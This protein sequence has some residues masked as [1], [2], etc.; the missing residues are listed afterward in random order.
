MA[1]AH[2]EDPQEY[3]KAHRSVA[4]GFRTSAAAW[5]LASQRGVDMPITEQVHQV[6]HRGRPLLDA[7]KALVT[8]AHKEELL[9][10][11]R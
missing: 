7:M 9:G 5:A 6:L 1:I 11:Q 10:L 2:G 3:V 4:E 8:R